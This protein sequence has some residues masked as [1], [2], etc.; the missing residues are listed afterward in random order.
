MILCLLLLVGV[1][2]SGPG[3][4]RMILPTVV[5]DESIN[6]E[7]E[8]LGLFDYITFRLQPVELQLI[9]EGATIDD[10]EMSEGLAVELPGETYL[11]LIL[12][13][14]SSAVFSE[15][16]VLSVIDD[17]MHLL[18]NLSVV[19]NERELEEVRLFTTGDGLF[20]SNEHVE[21]YIT[22]TYPG[23]E[24]SETYI[25]IVWAGDLDRDGKLD[26]LLN[27]V[28]GE[29]LRYSWDLYLSGEAS[30]EQ[31][32]RKVASFSSLYY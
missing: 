9:P 21:Q 22:E 30:P 28:R 10:T 11:P 8:W 2:E 6:P 1:D 13:S 14:S 4:Y 5:Y 7:D 23:K 15:G 31:L 20:L 25:G 16:P 18:P 26:L 32:V 17:Y 29:H 12:L 19:F 24:H 27:D 3:E